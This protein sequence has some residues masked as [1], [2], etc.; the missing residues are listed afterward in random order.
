MLFA[1]QFF[2]GR[3]QLLFCRFV[4]VFVVGSV[5]LLPPIVLIFLYIWLNSKLIIPYE[6]RWEL[7]ESHQVQ[8]SKPIVTDDSSTVYVIC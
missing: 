3:N 5:Q 7:Q 1:L 4:G 2:A 6:L 8:V